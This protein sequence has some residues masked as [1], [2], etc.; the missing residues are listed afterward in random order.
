MSLCSA[1][2]LLEYWRREAEAQ[3]KAMRKAKQAARQDRPIDSDEDFDAPS[4]W[5]EPTEQEAEGQMM[6]LPRGQS[7]D[8]VPTFDQNISRMSEDLR[9]MVRWAEEQK[10]KMKKVN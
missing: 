10:Q 8:G 9:D 1:L 6:F 2:D 4:E 3:L 5:R 7:V